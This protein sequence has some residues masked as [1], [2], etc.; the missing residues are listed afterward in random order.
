M[1]SKIIIK[2]GLKNH[3]QT[4]IQ[5]SCWIYRQQLPAGIRQE[6]FKI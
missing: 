6:K 5:Y 1:G 2:P 3:P 4:F